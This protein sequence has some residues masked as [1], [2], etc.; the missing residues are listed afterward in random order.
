VT[1][2]G[3][4]GG[5]GGRRKRDCRPGKGI[6]F[7]GGSWKEG[8]GGNPRML[9]AR[10]EK[11]APRGKVRED[12]GDLSPQKPEGGRL[13]VVSAGVFS[14]KE[15]RRKG[16]TSRQKKQRCSRFVGRKGFSKGDRV[17]CECLV[18]KK[19]VPGGRAIKSRRGS[20]GG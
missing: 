4:R 10:T 20:G 15:C 1:V 11:S 17:F 13:W 19:G 2:A 3:N 6:C 5:S 12:E 16:E 14:S 7:W 9:R 18:E 8:K